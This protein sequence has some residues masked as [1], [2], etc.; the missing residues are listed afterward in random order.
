MHFT[1]VVPAAVAGC[2]HLEGEAK[3]CF[4]ACHPLGNFCKMGGSGL[5]HFPFSPFPQLGNLPSGSLP[6]HMAPVFLL[7]PCAVT[8]VGLW[9]AQGLS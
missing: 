2:I 8:A 1:L 9:D 7:S 3:A 4:L 5:H 6:G